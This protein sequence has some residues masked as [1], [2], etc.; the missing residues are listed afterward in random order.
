MFRN[1]SKILQSSYIR[2]YASKPSVKKSVSTKTPLITCKVSKFD[3][4]VETAIPQDAKFGKIP[5]ASAAWQHYKA[6][7]DQFTI[8]AIANQPSDHPV[9]K[10]FDDFQLDEQI[11]K[12]LKLRLDVLNPNSI[13][14]SAFTP[15]IRN[16][17]TLIAAETG[18][19]KTLAYLIPIVQRILSL[20]QRQSNDEMNT[21]TAV[22]VTPGRELGE[23]VIDFA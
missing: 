19:G 14:S 10:S 22:I 9:D 13:Q 21:P 1:L 2:T 6:K 8:H 18:C 23:F 5:L 16:E 12:N 4:Y 7:G 11:V 3:Q 20:G 17:H 15:L